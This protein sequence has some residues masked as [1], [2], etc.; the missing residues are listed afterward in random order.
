MLCVVIAHRSCSFESAAGEGE[1][2]Y[3]MSS[4]KMPSTWKR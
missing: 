1:I 2:V 3:D 4:N